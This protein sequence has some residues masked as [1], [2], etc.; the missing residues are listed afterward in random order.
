MNATPEMFRPISPSESRPEQDATPTDSQQAPGGQDLPSMSPHPRM[1]LNRRGERVFV[2]GAASISFLHLI[3]GVVADQI[4]PSPFSHNDAN[5]T[6]MEAES[7][8]EPD[9]GSPL[10]TGLPGLDPETRVRYA[11]VFFAVVSFLW[12][13]VPSRY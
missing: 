5:G 11:K 8:Q 4:G 6:M 12:P 3:R 9:M 13:P 1:L 10:A 7:R 2:G